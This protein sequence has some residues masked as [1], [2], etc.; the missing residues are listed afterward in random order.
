MPRQKKFNSVTVLVSWLLIL[1]ALVLRL[2]ITNRW[3]DNGPFGAVRLYPVRGLLGTLS[4]CVDSTISWKRFLRNH[5]NILLLQRSH[6][7]AIPAHLMVNFSD[8]DEKLFQGTEN[9][10]MLQNTLSLPTPPPELEESPE[11]AWETCLLWH[12][13][14]KTLAIVNILVEELKPE[15]LL[16]FFFSFFLFLGFS[17]TS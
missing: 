2:W 5:L 4:S 8:R 14:G 12:L 1:G 7:V 9:S 13:I 11:H 16:P 15:D 10:M 3:E 6:A 17:S